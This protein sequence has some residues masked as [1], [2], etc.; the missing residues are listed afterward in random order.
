[1]REGLGLPVMEAIERGCIPIYSSSIP[2]AE[3][4]ENNLFEF[5]PNVVG[6][7]A[8][9]LNKIESMNAINPLK[10]NSIIQESI[11]EYNSKFE[12]IALRIRNFSF[13]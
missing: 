9:T 1:M 12:S 5:D 11:L 7:L 2:A 8:D 13:E 10:V 4:L 6:S 3:F